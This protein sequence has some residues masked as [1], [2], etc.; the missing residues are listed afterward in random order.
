MSALK[1]FR[2]LAHSLHSSLNFNIPGRN[3]YIIIIGPNVPKLGFRVVWPVD[4]LPQLKLPSQKGNQW[5]PSTWTGGESSQLNELREFRGR[6]S[7]MGHE[8]I[9]V[10]VGV[11]QS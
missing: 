10:K 8:I 6:V 5:P 1:Y 11:R 9:N 2:L 3:I 4:R 7:E